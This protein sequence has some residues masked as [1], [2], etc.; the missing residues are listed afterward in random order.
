MI[1]LRDAGEGEESSC[2]AQSATTMV[3]CRIVCHSDDDPTCTAML[4]ERLKVEIEARVFDVQ[5]VG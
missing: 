1:V 2:H 4:R 5:G 3:D